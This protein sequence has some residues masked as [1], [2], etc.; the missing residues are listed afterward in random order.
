MKPA[1][2][3]AAVLGAVLM[4]RRMVRGSRGVITAMRRE[5]D[6]LGQALAVWGVR[7]DARCLRAPVTAR[8]YAPG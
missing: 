8:D 5:L 1:V 3:S 2:H 7:L 6:T 4:C